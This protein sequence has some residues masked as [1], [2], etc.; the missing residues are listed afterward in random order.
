MPDISWSRLNHIEV[1]KRLHVSQ[2]EVRN[3][4]FRRNFSDVGLPMS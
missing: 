1:L 4:A 2:Y 3:R